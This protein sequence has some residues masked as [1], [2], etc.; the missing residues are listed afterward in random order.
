MSNQK[1]TEVH[2]DIVKNNMTANGI[3]APIMNG[4]N[5]TNG[6]KHAKT[7][8][9]DPSNDAAGELV[10]PIDATEAYRHHP[11]AYELSKRPFLEPRKLKVIVAGAG[12]SALSFAHEVETGNL[13]NIDLTILEK[14]AGLGGTWFENRYPGCACDIP[15]HAY[16]VGLQD[17]K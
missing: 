15:A 16:L 3:P 6:V 10:A 17:F 14:N 1:A 8:G 5:T 13:R 2:V 4:A 11:I 7:N 12:A 9:H